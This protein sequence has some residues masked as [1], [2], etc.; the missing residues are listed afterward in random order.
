MPRNISFSMTM[1]QFKARTKDVTRRLGWW[2]TKAG[3]VLCA[4]EQVMGLKA[5]QKIVRLG[6]IEVVR[7]HNEPLDHITPADV[8]REGFPDWDPEQFIDFFMK[9]NRCNGWTQ[10]RRIEFKYLTRKR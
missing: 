6:L 8:V 5:G 9:A 1:P 2:N 4:C 3:E 10:I 7:A